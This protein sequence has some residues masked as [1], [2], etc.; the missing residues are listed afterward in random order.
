MSHQDA[1]WLGAGAADIGVLSQSLRQL[2]GGHGEFAITCFRGFGVLWADDRWWEID[3]IGSDVDEARTGAAFSTAWVVARRFL[4][5]SA[6]Q[7]LSYARSAALNS[8]LTN[9]SGV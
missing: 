1:R 6:P 3:P 4:R 9:Q 7:A 2:Q 5:A 8:T